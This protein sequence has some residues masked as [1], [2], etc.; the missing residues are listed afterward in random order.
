MSHKL[1]LIHSLALGVLVAAA[2]TEDSTAPESPEIRTPPALAASATAALSFRQVSSGLFHSCGITTAG[3]AY[4]WGLNTSGQLGT[5]SNTGPETC[6]FGNGCSTRPVAV[7]GGLQFRQISAGGEHTCGITSENRVYCWGNNSSNQ[8]GQPTDAG[9]ETCGGN[10]CSAR[11]IEVAGGRRFRQV[12]AGGFHT[13][14]VTPLN[15]PF[16]WGFNASGQL[17]D[18]TTTQRV[19]PVAVQ[20]GGRAF[21][22]VTSG[23]RH[24]C[25]LTTG[26]RAYCWGSGIQTGANTRDQQNTPVPVF[27]GLSFSNLSAGSLH[28]CGVTT[29]SRA[30]CWGSN[31][32]G[33]TGDG[34]DFPNR[35]KPTAVVGGLSFR[36]V[37]AGF[38]ESCGLTT[39]NKPYCWGGNWGGTPALVPGGFR[40]AQL[41]TGGHSCALTS[42]SVAYCWGDDNFWGQLGDGTKT[43]HDTPGRVVGPA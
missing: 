4:C 24:T 14:A 26:N 36:T 34:T 17:G 13:C 2:C 7:T 8:L 15:K 35:L 21:A 25:G 33:K 41:D 10:D 37:S 11:P 1:L 22:A 18:G 32:L 31:A 16:C 3:V 42:G 38:R 9:S 5:G 20:T 39:V 40:F 23:S 6:T 12:S 27:G 28:T 30:Y 29:N 19:T 43:D